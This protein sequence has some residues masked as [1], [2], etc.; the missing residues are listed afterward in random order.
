MRPLSRFQLISRHWL[1]PDV[2]WLLATGNVLVTGIDL[3]LFV[4]RIQPPFLLWKGGLGGEE[5]KENTS[6]A[7]RRGKNRQTLSPLLVRSGT[8]PKIVPS[9]R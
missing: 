2:L 8:A 7:A 4:T 6:Q 1:L 9:Y 3:A 5:I